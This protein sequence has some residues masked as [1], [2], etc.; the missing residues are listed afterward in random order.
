ML[1]IIWGTSICRISRR[2]LEFLPFWCLVRGRWILIYCCVSCGRINLAE[3][4]ERELMWATI[5][6]LILNSRALP[7]S[8]SCW[9][10]LSLIEIVRPLAQ[11][12]ISTYSRSCAW[13][14]LHHG[15]KLFGWLSIICIEAS[16]HQEREQLLVNPHY[17]LDQMLIFLMDPGDVHILLGRLSRILKELV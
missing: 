8:L 2:L 16:L 12:G 10:K 11:R 15:R 13:R 17:F 1:I 9:H 6:R 4:I 3:F 7:R 14:S 5:Q